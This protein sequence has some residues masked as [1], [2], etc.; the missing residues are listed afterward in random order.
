[1]K[2]QGQLLIDP[3]PE[4]LNAATLPGAGLVLDARKSGCYTAA[5][6]GEAISAAHESITVGDEQ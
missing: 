3:E 1:M 6:D 4:V 2:R 5:T